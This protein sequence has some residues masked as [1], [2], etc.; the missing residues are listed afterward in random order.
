MLFFTYTF[1]LIVVL[2]PLFLTLQQSHATLGTFSNK[3]EVEYLHIDENGMENNEVERYKGEK[4][5]DCNMVE[6]YYKIYQT[7]FLSPGTKWTI[8]YIL[9][10]K[11]GEQGITMIFP[12]C[13]M[14]QGLVSSDIALLNGVW[15]QSCSILGSFLGGIITRSQTWLVRG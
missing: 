5:K 12:M 11:L 13:L 10:Y 8:L 15:C 14:E 4:G 1:V 3:Q 6:K 7:I 9:V 2:L